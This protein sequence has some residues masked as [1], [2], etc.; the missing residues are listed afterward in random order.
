MWA[1][2]KR[3]L[4]LGFLFTFEL[5]AVIIVDGSWAIAKAFDTVFPKKKGK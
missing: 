2:I 4:I 3:T 1:K 5:G